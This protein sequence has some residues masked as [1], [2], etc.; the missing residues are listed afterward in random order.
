MLKIS[1]K[2]SKMRNRPMFNEFD[3]I[4]NSMLR[5][6]S[7]R[8][9]I[10]LFC[11]IGGFHI[12][13]NNLG[14]ECVFASD[15][16]DEARNVYENN[17]GIRPAGDI[18]TIATDQIPPH[19][20]LFGG[21]P[22]QPFSIIGNRQGF[23]DQRNGGLFFEIARIAQHHQP[24]I[25]VLE[26][27]K[28]L[29]TAQK[30]QTMAKIIK[31]L[32]EL[33]YSVDSKVLNALN[34]GLPQKRERVLIVASKRPLKN[35]EW[36]DN[37]IS[38]K[39]LAKILEKNPDKRHF[40]SARIKEARLAL[41]STKTKPAIWHEN[42]AGNISSHPYSCALRAGASH[43][44]LLVNGERRLTPRELARLQGFPDS[45]EIHNTDIQAR[46]QAGNAVPVPMV[47]AVIKSMLEAYERP[48]TQVGKTIRLISG[49]NSPDYSLGM[50]D[51]RAKLDSTGH[52]VLSICNKR[53][54][55][56]R[57]R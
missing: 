41:H 15:I 40:V 2:V 45:F 9:Y 14:L 25:I 27:V 6:P 30:G 36:P 42:K 5:L 54:A 24:S 1:Q 10:D 4:T 19:D 20:I 38:M 3:N 22:C 57:C 26:N 31:T 34:F 48:L 17:F 46:K 28:R 50:S 53:H 39:P 55:G 8:T 11:G 35:F 43:N 13:A 23:E 51:P 29:A 52:A 33:G 49:R 21:F 18:T 12:A 32:E 44:Y 37:I 16:D 7:C 56:H 47:Q